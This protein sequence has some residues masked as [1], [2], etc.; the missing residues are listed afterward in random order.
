MTDIIA[1][2][3]SQILNAEKRGKSS[4]V[5]KPVSKLLREVIGIMKDEGY[6]GEFEVIDD[7]KGGILNLNLTGELN[8]CGAIKPR[9]SPKVNEFEKFEKRYLPSKDFGTL[10]L[11]TTKGVISLKKAKKEKIGGQLLAYVY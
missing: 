4:C 5:I 7:G 6:V 2:A 1:Q 9:F 11:S 3:L 10:I 8:G